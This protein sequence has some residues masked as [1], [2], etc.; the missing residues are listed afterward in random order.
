ME[1]SGQTSVRIKP[2]GYVHH[3]ISKKKKKKE[4]KKER[5]ERDWKKKLLLF[6][7]PSAT[8]GPLKLPPI[9]EVVRLIA[10]SARPS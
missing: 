5:K 4:R 9:S 2:E 1:E 7:P 10:K 3:K 6:E 8:F